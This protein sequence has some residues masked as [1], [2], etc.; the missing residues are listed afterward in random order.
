M[1]KK[2]WYTSK[3][4][5]ASVLQVG[6]GALVSAGLLSAEATKELVTAGPDVIVGIIG[7]ALGAF[8]LYG[9]VTAKTAIGKKTS[10]I[11]TEDSK[12]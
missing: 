12:E 8:S 6:V 4:C 7:S 10:S 2:P 11:D 3:A 1:N 5:W 9:R